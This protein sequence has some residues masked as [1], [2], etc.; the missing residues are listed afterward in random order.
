MF[1]CEF[2]CQDIPTKDYMYLSENTAYC[3]ET[4]VFIAHTECSDPCGWPEETI[5][6]HGVCKLVRNPPSYEE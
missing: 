3:D 4:W 1:K 2:C 5:D 6:T